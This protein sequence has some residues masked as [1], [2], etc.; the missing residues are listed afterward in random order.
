MTTVE[1]LAP[2][3]GLHPLQE[4]FKEEHG[5]QC[6]FCTPG[7]ML[8]ASALLEENPD[9]SEE[10]IRWAISGNICRCTGYQN[11]VKA[12]QWAR[13]RSQPRECRW[14]RRGPRR[15]AG[16]ARAS[17]ARRTTRFVVGRGNYIDDITLPDMLHMAILRSP[18]AHA[19][20]NSIDTSTRDGASRRRRG[21][22]RRAARAAQPRVDADALGRHAGRARDRQGAHAGPGGRVRDRRRPV[23]RARRARADRR[24]LR[25]AARRSPRRSRRSS[26]GAP[27][28]PRRQGG[29]GRQH[30]L[31]LGGRRRRGDRARVRGGRPGRPARD[32]LPAL[33]PVAARVL[34]LRRGRQPGD[35][36]GDDLHDLAG[37]ARAPHGVRAR[38]RAAGAEHPDHL[39]GHR[40]RLRQQGAGL[41]GLRRRDGRVAPDRPAG[42]VDRGP[43]R[44]P[45]LDR[46]RAR[47]PHGRRAR[48]QGR[49]EDDR[50]SA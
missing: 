41:P 14:R 38:R 45:D 49:R 32:A 46:L 24:R 23:R 4:G 10:E 44:Q 27:R 48:A 39:A 18:F 33:A 13:P 15:S 22:H 1:G 19:T 21:R 30:G 50:R 26:R 12:V 2:A 9:P 7:M 35:R 11:I 43:H 25:P 28:H 6:G 16:S 36:Q 42:E 29:P 34:R 3:G 40:R 8:I 5:L 31:P 17:S 37:A 47:L 20:I